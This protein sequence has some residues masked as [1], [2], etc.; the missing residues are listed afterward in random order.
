MLVPMHESPS[1]SEGKSF[2]SVRWKEV[3]VDEAGDI[4]EDVWGSGLGKR[5]FRDSA[6]CLPTPGSTPIPNPC[7]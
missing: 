7:W 6:R 2:N 1:A 4:E 3:E 5:G